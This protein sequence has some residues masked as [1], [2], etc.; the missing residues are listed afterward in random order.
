MIRASR[1]ATY[2]ESTLLFLSQLASSAWFT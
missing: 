1:R 2:A